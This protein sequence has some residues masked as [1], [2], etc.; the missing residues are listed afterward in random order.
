V[1]L[2][3]IANANAALRAIDGRRGR[4]RPKHYRRL[5]RDHA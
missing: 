2:T 4:L 3:G 1:G 5:D